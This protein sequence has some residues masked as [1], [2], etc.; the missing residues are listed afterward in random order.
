MKHLEAQTRFLESNA[1]VCLVM[2]DDVIL[3]E[4]FEADLVKVLELSQELDPGW[5]IFLGGADNKIDDRFLNQDDCLIEQDLSTAEVYLLDRCG[6]E[7][8]MEWLKSNKL[9]RQA[10]HQIKLI[11]RDLGIKHFWFSR[12]L[13]T[14][15]SITGMFRTALD[16]S[17]GKRSANYLRVKFWWNRFRRQ[18]APKLLFRLKKFIIG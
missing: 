3:F 8:R 5:L 11:D 9:D 14:Q 10:D 15:G 17:R 7:Q 4:T 16:H 13:A 12:P 1:R 6:C 2:E 18:L